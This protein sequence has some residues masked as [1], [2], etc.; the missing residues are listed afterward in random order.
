MGLGDVGTASDAISDLEIGSGP[1]V[2]CIDAE[3]ARGFQEA[4]ARP[5]A[6]TYQTLMR[7]G[8]S[9]Q[10]NSMRLARHREDVR[11]RFARILAECR[12]GVRMDDN[13][14][15]SYGLK[16]HRIYPMSPTDPAPTITPLPDAVLHY[17]E[18]RSEE[19]RVG[20]GG[21]RTCRSRW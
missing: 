21:V 10:P 12:R 4:F 19:R 2:E 13:A 11:E 16:K 8:A 6:T 15:R 20:K 5:P 14:R 1:L 9:G 17:S 18:P 3:S 7:E